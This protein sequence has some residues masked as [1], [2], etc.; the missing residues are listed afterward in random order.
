MLAHPLVRRLHLA[1]FLVGMVAW[2]VALLSPVPEE[3]AE[4]VFGS[5]DGVFYFGK[6]L[7]VVAY[8]A[9]T[10]F[11]GMMHY[12]RHSAHW[13][14]VALCVH[15]GL[16]EILQPHFGRGGKWADWGLDSIGIAGGFIL[17]RAWWRW[18]PVALTGVTATPGATV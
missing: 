17:V 11:A 2:S 8:L 12:A 14:A 7:H 3:D 1:I 15:G 18:G 9:L 10:L 5:R 6:T 16:I 4:R 13:W